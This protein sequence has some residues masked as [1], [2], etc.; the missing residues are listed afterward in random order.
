MAKKRNQ[1][2]ESNVQPTQ[3]APNSKYGPDGELVRLPAPEFIRRRRRR[4]AVLVGMGIALSGIVVMGVIAFLGQ[5][6]G[7]FTVQLVGDARAQLTLGTTL[8]MNDVGTADVTD[9]TSYL[10]ASGFRATSTILADRLYDDFGG[11]DVLDADIDSSDSA[12]GKKNLLGNGDQYWAYTFYLKNQE[13]A[14][15]HFSYGMVSTVNTEPDNVDESVS[16]KKILRVRVY[17]NTYQQNGSITHNMTTYAW[18]RD[19]PNDQGNYREYI[20]DPYMTGFSSLYDQNNG[21]CE[22]F[23]EQPDS[24]NFTVFKLDGSLRMNEIRRYTVLMWFA[25]DDQDTVLASEQ[26]KGGAITFS[27]TFTGGDK[28]DENQ[29]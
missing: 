11:D 6:S 4:R 2:P 23:E 7:T 17:E 3:Q 26:P 9:K 19:T 16:L 18:K 14:F 12:E 28:S 8:G 20:Q 21:L 15:A 27:M 24:G 25:A 10:N 22:F 13:A 1:N 29:D 5:R